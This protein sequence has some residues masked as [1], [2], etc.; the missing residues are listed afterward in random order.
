MSHKTTSTVECNNQSER[1]DTIN[2]T[3]TLREHFVEHFNAC[4]AKATE[5]GC[6]A[7]AAEYAAMADDIAS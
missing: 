2:T 4:A 3:G 6:D 1:V 7:L 5:L